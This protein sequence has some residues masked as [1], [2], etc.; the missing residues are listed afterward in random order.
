MLLMDTEGV[1]LPALAASLLH[2]TGHLAM[3]LL[4]GSPPRKIEC[5]LIGFQIENHTMTFNYTQDMLVSLAGAAV[6]ILTFFVCFFFTRYTT[7]ALVNLCIGV[8]N[9]LPVHPLDGSRVLYCLLCRKRGEESARQ[10]VR[11]AAV[12]VLLPLASAGFYLFITSGY[13]PSLFLLVIYLVLCY[14][15]I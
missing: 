13:N 15:K 14:N 9:L 2:E 3:M 7:F 4:L 12:L 5:R 11:R 6:N 8:L 10:W 1:V